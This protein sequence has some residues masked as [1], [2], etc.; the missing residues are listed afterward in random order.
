MTIY[1]YN[2][3]KVDK[4]GIYSSLKHKYG[5]K[6]KDLK[7]ECDNLWSECVKARAG[8]KSEI[9]GRTGILHSHHIK[10]KAT[11]RLRYELDNGICLTAGEHK[12]GVHLQSR[13]DDYERRISEAKG[14]EVMEKLSNISK[15]QCGSPDLMGIKLYLENELKSHSRHA[16]QI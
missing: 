10:G 9:S 5:A 12:F 7:K 3:K 6:R 2:R 16:I 14:K 1:A 8:Y 15:F 13:K 4:K 11:Y